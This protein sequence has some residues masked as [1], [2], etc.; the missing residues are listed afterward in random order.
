VASIPRQASA[1]S[2]PRAAR[3]DTLVTQ[4]KLT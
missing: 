2:P 1:I 4:L 3:I